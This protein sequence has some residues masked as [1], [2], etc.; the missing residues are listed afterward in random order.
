MSIKLQLSTA[1]NYSLIGF[2]YFVTFS[3]IHQEYE[4]LLMLEF[5]I[6]KT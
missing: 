1:K 5:S 3:A 2:V 6:K 4:Y